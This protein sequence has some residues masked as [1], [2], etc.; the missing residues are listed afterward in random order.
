MFEFLAYNMLF[1]I[2]SIDGPFAF[3][4]ATGLDIVFF[5]VFFTRVC[6]VNV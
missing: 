3:G 1:S 2:L 5:F 4:E 6:F